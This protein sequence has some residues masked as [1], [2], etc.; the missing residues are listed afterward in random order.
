MAVPSF[1]EANQDF[2]MQFR[3]RKTFS[4]LV[5]RSGDVVVER[6]Y[7]DPTSWNQHCE[8]P[9]IRNRR[10][11]S[12]G[13]NWCHFCAIFAIFDASQSWNHHQQAQV[14]MTC[15]YQYFWYV[16]CIKLFSCV[17][18]VLAVR[19]KKISCTVSCVGKTC[20]LRTAFSVFS[21]KTLPY[22]V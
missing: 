21:P 7:Q 2:L 13:S 1:W 3:P 15:T 19:T 18:Q 6:H 20:S 22:K 5:G 4:Q 9:L 10:T 16:L 12:I 8:F 17:Q 11:V 14:Q